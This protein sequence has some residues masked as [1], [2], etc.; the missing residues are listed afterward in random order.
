MALASCGGVTFGGG[1]VWNQSVSRGP[2]KTLTTRTPPGRNSARN[3]WEADK[4]A[5]W[6]AENAPNAGQLAREKIHT[7]FSFSLP[8]QYILLDP[9]DVVTLTEPRLGLAR[10]L[11]AHYICL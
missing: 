2:Q 6:L 5:A 3:A 11:R 10:C 8:P 1:T 4:I 7:E 9:G